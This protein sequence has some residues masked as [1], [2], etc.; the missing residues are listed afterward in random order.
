M[1]WKKAEFDA[2]FQ[3]A[4]DRR[5]PLVPIIDECFRVA[6]PMHEARKADVSADTDSSV[7]TADYYDTTATSA[8][9]DL[10]SELLDLVWPLDAIPFDLQLPRRFDIDATERERINVRLN[11]R[12]NILIEEINGSGG[13][14][15]GDW[16]SATHSAL[17]DYTVSQGFVLRHHGDGVDALIRWTHQPLKNAY[18]LRGPWGETDILFI[19][20]RMPRRA[21][22]QQWPGAKAKAPPNMTEK[23][24]GES[25]EVRQAL[26]RD[27]SVSEETWITQV[28]AEGFGAREENKDNVF[29]HTATETGHGS[30]PFLD[31]GY[32]RVH[33]DTLCRGP[34]QLALA[35]IQLIN[36]LV[37]NQVDMADLALWG[38]W[39]FEDDA[40]QPGQVRIVPREVVPVTPGSGSLKRVDATPNVQF[41]GDFEQRR[42]LRIREMV[43]GSDLGPTDKTPMSATEVIERRAGSARRRAGPYRRLVREL[44]A[45]TVM[46]TNWTLER[47]GVLPPITSSRG[48]VKV[49]PGMFRPVAPIT[50]LQLMDELTRVTRLLE[51]ITASLGPEVAAAV[52]KLEEI[53]PFFADRLGVPAGLLKNRAEIKD[54]I[55]DL[56]KRM[57]A[58]AGSNGGAA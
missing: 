27:N 33:G 4:K 8:C 18:P 7:Y 49:I 46:A 24:L 51:L 22:V 47:R 21:I 42:A 15:G 45:R 13:L 20:S 53:I 1:A 34:L 2:W 19:V 37:E 39:T 55:A 28:W 11:E 3:Q 38:I 32:L 9:E 43:Y 17:F 12:A 56:S 25:V 50:R 26:Y 58:A 54:V 6:L 52:S 30:R 48:D 23:M 29:I 57:S 40:F 44:Q 10:V 5:A 16:Y 35:E 14:G 31:F 36:A 41:V